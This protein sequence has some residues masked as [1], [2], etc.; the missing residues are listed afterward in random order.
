MSLALKGPWFKVWTE[1]TPLRKEY[2]RHSSPCASET[3]TMRLYKFVYLQVE[4]SYRHQFWVEG[5]QPGERIH[6]TFLRKYHQCH[7]HAV[8]DF[9][10]SLS[11]NLESRYSSLRGIHCYFSSVNCCTSSVTV[12]VI[13]VIPHDIGKS[14]YFYFWGALFIAKHFHTKIHESRFKKITLKD[15]FLSPGILLWSIKNSDTCYS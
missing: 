6:Q 9:G 3:V 5:T 2:I 14:W 8:Q 15:R 11:P 1:H 13:I 12:D 4:R 7:H 10:K